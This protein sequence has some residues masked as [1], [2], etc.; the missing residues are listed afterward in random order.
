MR[1]VYLKNVSKIL[2]TNFPEKNHKTPLFTLTPPYPQI[3]IVLRYPAMSHL[4][5]YDDPTSY[6]EL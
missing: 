5:P 2:I 3:K 1:N 4:Y 6:K